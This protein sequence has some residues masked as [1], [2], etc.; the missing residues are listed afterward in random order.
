MNLLG[1]L[2]G[3]VATLSGRLTELED[4]IAQAERQVAAGRHFSSLQQ[5][6]VPGVEAKGSAEVRLR[7][8]I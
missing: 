2:P 4:N 3:A 8:I 7:A 1:H 5:F 6:G